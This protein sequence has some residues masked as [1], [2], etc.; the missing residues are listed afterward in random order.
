MSPTRGYSSYRGRS[1]L[2]KK[3]L[4]ILLLLVI[5]AAGAVVA[6][7]NHIVYDDNGTAHLVLPGKHGGA[8]SAESSAGGSSSE[9]LNITVDESSAPK[10][11]RAVQLPQTAYSQWQPD[12]WKSCWDG[13]TPFNALAVTVKDSGGQVFYD[14][15]AAKAVTGRSGSETDAQALHTL[16]EAASGRYLIARLSCL[17]DPAAAKA[18]VEGMGLKNTGGFI[19]YD[20]SSANWLDPAKQKT[21]EYLCGLAKECA[22]LGFHEILLSDV[23]YPTAGK[24]D[25]ID[26]GSGVNRQETLEAL[27]GAV[28]D[29]LAAEYPDVK[30]SIELPANVITAGSDETAGL[31]LTAMARHVSRIW[32]VCAEADAPSLA[33]SVAAAGTDGVPGFIPELTADVPP[34]QIGSALP[35]SLPDYLLSVR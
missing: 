14:S 27:V 35:Q 34:E 26:Y 8:G 5:L 32:A 9:E 17:L 2:W 29:A 3:L 28:S 31:S 12:R 25:K 22:A 13:S 23:S 18:D 15:A 33:R 4:A 30:L 7:Q 19:F 21:V 10:E 1:P 6:L 11:L 16:M 24:L 20:G